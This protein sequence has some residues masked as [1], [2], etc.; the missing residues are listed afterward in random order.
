MRFVS[1]SSGVSPL[2]LIFI[3]HI[4]SRA[5]VVGMLSQHVCGSCL[6]VSAAKVRRLPK[7]DAAAS[8]NR[9]ASVILRVLKR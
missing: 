5:E 7:T 8:R 6:P 9:F 1:R 3:A 2:M 4:F